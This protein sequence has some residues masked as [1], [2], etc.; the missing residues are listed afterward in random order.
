MSLIDADT[1]DVLPFTPPIALSTLPS[2]VF[3][4]ASFELTSVSWPL[5]VAI[6]ALL[7]VSFRLASCCSASGGP[8]CC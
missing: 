4:V 6:P 7:V 2:V 3:M 8:C 1:S 5:V